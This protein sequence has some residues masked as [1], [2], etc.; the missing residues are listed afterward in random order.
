[1]KDVNTALKEMLD[2]V[3]TKAPV[4]YFENLVYVLTHLVEQ[5]KALA[6]ELRDIKTHSALA[7]KWDAKVAR[8]MIVDI[9]AKLRKDGSDGSSD[10]SVNIFTN[11]IAGLKQA[12]VDDKVTQDYETFC[13][14]W[15]DTL[16]WHPF[17]RY[18]K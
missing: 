8:N 4:E 18:D 13:Q 15:T 5:N 1:M 6:T 17:L 7:I 3:G 14:F 10:K 9:I 11:E 16:G 2:S 12:F